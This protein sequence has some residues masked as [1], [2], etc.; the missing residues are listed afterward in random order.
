VN[1]ETVK[2]VFDT[3]I[4]LRALINP[5]SVCGRLF[6]EWYLDYSQ[7]VCDE[8]DKEVLDVLSRSSI[9]R[10][11]PQITDERIEYVASRLAKAYRVELQLEDIE[12]I[13][14]DPKDDIF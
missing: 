2:V 6:F 7:Y 1:S 11:F 4:Y 9:R 8:I 3:Q 5:R 10:K 12:P 13:C 14:R